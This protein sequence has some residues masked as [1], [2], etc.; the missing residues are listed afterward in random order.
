MAYMMLL[1][2]SAI[3]PLFSFYFSEQMAY[4]FHYRKL[5]H[6]D[7]WFW[8]RELSDEAL[9]EI[10]HQKSRKFGKIAAW[11]VSTICISVFAY[12]SFLNFT[13]NL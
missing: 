4:H 6:S 9:D 7:K 5:G 12:V 11:I 13:E 1:V 2:I 10:A 8:E 3:T